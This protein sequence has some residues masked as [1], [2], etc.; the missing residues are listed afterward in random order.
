MNKSNKDKRIDAGKAGELYNSLASR[1]EAIIEKVGEEKAHELFR[2][3]REQGFGYYDIDKIETEE[4]FDNLDRILT[5][6]EKQ[7]GIK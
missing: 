2:P 4:W 1:G 5:V 3:M 6:I 7:V